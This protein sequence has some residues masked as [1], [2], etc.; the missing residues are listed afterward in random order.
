MLRRHD[1]QVF[2]APV[3]GVWTPRPEGPKVRDNPGAT[4]ILDRLEART[5]LLLVQT[6]NS[7]AKG[8][9]YVCKPL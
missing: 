1:K 2:L 4:P 9:L 8:L 5:S 3:V 6:R 7:Q